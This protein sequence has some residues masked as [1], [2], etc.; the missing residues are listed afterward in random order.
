MRFRAKGRKEAELNS[1]EDKERKENGRKDAPEMQNTKLAAFTA[2][3]RQRLPYL[4]SLEGIGL[5]SAE[6]EDLTVTEDLGGVL[7]IRESIRYCRRHFAY[8]F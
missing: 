5:V 3:S 1:A 2:R 7:A 6:D 8:C 4:L